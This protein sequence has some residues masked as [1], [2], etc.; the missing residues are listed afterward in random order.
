[1]LALRDE[2]LAAQSNM[3]ADFSSRLAT[4]EASL[5]PLTLTRDNPALYPEPT[6]PLAPAVNV[7]LVAKL[8]HRGASGVLSLEVVEGG[9]LVSGSDKFI[10]TWA[11]GADRG[12]GSFAGEAIRITALPGGQFATAGDMTNIVEVWDLD[13]GKRFKQLRGHTGGVCCVAAL[14]GGFLAFGGL[15]NT[16]RI[17]NAGTG[18]LESTLE[19]HTFW[20]WALAVL[21]DGRLASGS[22]DGTIR[23]WNVAARTCQVLRHQSNVNALAVLD[24]DRIASGCADHRVYIWTV[25]G[26]VLEAEFKGHTSDVISLAALRIG[27]LASGSDDRTVRVWDVGARACVAVLEGHG[28]EVCALAALP[29]GRFASGSRGDPLI[30]VWAVTVPGSFEAVAAGTAAVLCPVVAAAAD[31]KSNVADATGGV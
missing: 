4:V 21:R 9:K 3:L 5:S 29:Y 10:C 17:W 18:A 31:A 24:G 11:Q 25:A 12:L 26:G 13:A 22:F 19:G 2:V 6:T 23:L 7:R 16:V 30:R 20:V 1:M 8:S 14:P 27:L 28:G 15:D